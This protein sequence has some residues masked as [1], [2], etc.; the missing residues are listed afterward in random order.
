AKISLGISRTT[1]IV[2]QSNLPLERNTSCGYYRVSGRPRI[3]PIIGGI[4][5]AATHHPWQISLRTRGAHKCGASLINQ[6]W[7]LTAAHCV[8]LP[9]VLPRDFPTAAV[10]GDY[11][12]TLVESTEEEM[13]IR[14]IHTHPDWTAFPIPTNDIAL[15]RLRNCSK[16]GIPVCLPKA[17]SN[18]PA[19][20]RCVVSGYGTTNPTR[21]VYPDMLQ[22]ATVPLIAH[23]KCVRMYSRVVD[24]TYMQDSMLCAGY[25]E[26]GVDSC[27]GDSGGPLVCTDPTS[28]SKVQIGIVSWGNGCAKRNRPGVYTKISHFTEWIE[29]VINHEI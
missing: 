13:S 21:E 29:S 4:R 11:D 15:I 10:L 14:D 22:E 17:S 7:A 8:A 20:T 1:V 16:I 12:T 26:G 3:Q 2:L 19:G 25:I 28:E 18:F 6:C 24:K 27:Q 23:R 9:N 5:A